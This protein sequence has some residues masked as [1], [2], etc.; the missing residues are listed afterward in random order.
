MSFTASLNIFSF[1]WYLLKPDGCRRER[2]RVKAKVVKIDATGSEYTWRYLLSE[3]Y[4]TLL[5]CSDKKVTN[6]QE[7]NNAG[8]AENRLFSTGTLHGVPSHPTIE[9]HTHEQSSAVSIVQQYRAL[10]P[11]PF[12]PR[13][14][15]A[16]LRCTTVILSDFSPAYVQSISYSKHTLYNPH[17]N[18]GRTSPRLRPRPRRSCFTCVFR[19]QNGRDNMSP[20]GESL[21]GW[22]SPR[23]SSWS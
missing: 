5:G 14:M 19:G 6:N 18:R 8:G 10:L 20:S 22:Q 17:W 16:K 12:Q 13:R 2:I 4:S 15:D 7:C 9:P 3:I 11:N 1:D 21:L 23:S